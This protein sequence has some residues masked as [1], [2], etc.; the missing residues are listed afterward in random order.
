VDKKRFLTLRFWNCR[1][2]I[3]FNLIEI[4]NVENQMPNAIISSWR[5]GKIIVFFFDIS[6]LEYINFDIFTFGVVQRNPRYWIQKFA[7]TFRKWRRK[8][9]MKSLDLMI[10]LYNIYTHTWNMSC[11]ELS[12]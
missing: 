7:C 1:D 10:R 8:Q 6:I 5:R 3:N 11:H 9:K 12:T 4:K 2:M